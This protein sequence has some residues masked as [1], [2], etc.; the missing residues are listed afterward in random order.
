MAQ[1]RQ[2]TNTRTN[3]IQWFF[4]AYSGVTINKNLQCIGG[5]W[6]LEIIIHLTIVIYYK[7]NQA[8]IT[9]LVITQQV[10]YYTSKSENHIIESIIGPRIPLSPVQGSDLTDISTEV[11][12]AKSRAELAE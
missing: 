4:Y 12:E 3:L 10:F 6:V 7:Y 1:H 8:N 2:K 5:T 9:S 11:Y